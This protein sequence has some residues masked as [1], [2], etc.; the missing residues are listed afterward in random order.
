MTFPDG[1]P[2]ASSSRHGTFVQASNFRGTAQVSTEAEWRF[3]ITDNGLLGDVVFAN[4]STFTLE[5]AGEA[6]GTSSWM[7]G[8]TSSRE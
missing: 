3:R 8:A 7:T 1:S 4:M 2:G 6:G 5:R